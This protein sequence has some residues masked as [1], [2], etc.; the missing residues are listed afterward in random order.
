MSKKAISWID[1]IKIKGAERKSKGLAAG[2]R[3]VIPEAKTEWQL[4]KSGKHSKYTQGKPTRKAKGNKKS[5]KKSRKANKNVNVSSNDVKDIL[6]K[7][8]LC[9]KC[10]N[11]VKKVLKQKGGFQMDEY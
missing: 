8:K 2:V 5:S 1:L 9:K 4:I 6:E 7:C 3:D 11:K 10:A